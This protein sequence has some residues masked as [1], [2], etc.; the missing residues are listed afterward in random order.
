MY[1]ENLESQRK[2][3]TFNVAPSLEI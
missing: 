2:P 3:V 1:I